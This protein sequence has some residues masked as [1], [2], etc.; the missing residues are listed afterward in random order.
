MRWLVDRSAGKTSKKTNKGTATRWTAFA[1]KNADDDSDNDDDL[2]A[3]Y[4]E[5][6]ALEKYGATKV[7]ERILLQKR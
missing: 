5:E 7:Y 2:E 3:E 1:R 6:L 4:G